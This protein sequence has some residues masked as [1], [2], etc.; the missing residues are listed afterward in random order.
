MVLFFYDRRPHR[1]HSLHLTGKVN[2]YLSNKTAL[3]LSDVVVVVVVAAV[4]GFLLYFFL[5][6]YYFFNVAFNQH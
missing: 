4:F 3:E 6:F 1:L 2:A 5:N